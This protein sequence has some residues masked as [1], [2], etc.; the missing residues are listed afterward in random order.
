MTGM[1]ETVHNLWCS[2]LLSKHKQNIL[3]KEGRWTWVD[4]CSGFCHHGTVQFE[5]FVLQGQEMPL[6]ATCHVLK[7][8]SLAV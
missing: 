3:A 1:Q 7:R 5:S 2:K 8:N 6:K 4:K